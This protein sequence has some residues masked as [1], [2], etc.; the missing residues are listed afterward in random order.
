MQKDFA[1]K[2]LLIRHVTSFQEGKKQ[3]AKCDLCNEEFAYRSNM[4][5]HAKTVHTSDRKYKCGT[6]QQSFKDKASIKMHIQAVHENIR[7]LKC[8]MCDKTFANVGNMKRHLTG[9]HQQKNR[10]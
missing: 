6:C 5:R 9:V 8:Q 10:D 7:Q 4:L 2:K 3:N 1:T